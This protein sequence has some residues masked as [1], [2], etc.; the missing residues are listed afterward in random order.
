VVGRAFAEIGE[1]HGEGWQRTIASA[2]LTF[3]NSRRYARGEWLL[4]SVLAPAGTGNGRSLEQFVV[5]GSTNPLIDPAFLAQRVALPAVPAGFVSGRLVQ[6]FRGALG[7]GSWE[8]Y[9][10]WVA[11]GDSLRDYKRIAGIERAFS[12]ASLGFA[13]L[14]GVRARGG[15][16]W[17]FDE[18]FKDRPRVYASLTYTP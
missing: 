5:G 9:F 18:P 7:Q 1:T 12:V 15:A 10:T 2:T 17:S 16:S 14:P 8:P 4:G 11:G 3:G 6:V 13:R